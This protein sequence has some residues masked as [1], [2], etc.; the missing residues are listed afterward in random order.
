MKRRLSDAKTDDIGTVVLITNRGP[1]RRR[2][3]DVGFTKGSRVQCLGRS[4]L[5]DPIAFGVKG[6]VIALRREDAAGIWIEIGGTSS[7]D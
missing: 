6:S 2:L 4:P 7:W 3:A 5:G 1:I